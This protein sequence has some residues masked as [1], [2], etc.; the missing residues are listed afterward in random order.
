M[1]INNWPNLVSMFFDQVEANALKPMLHAKKD[2][3]WVS[4]SWQEVAKQVA[5]LAQALKQMGIEKGDRVVLVSENRPEWAIADLAIM[6]AGAI[7]VPTYTTYTPRDYLHILENSGAKAAIVSTKALSMT[8]LKAAHESEDLMHTICMEDPDLS[9]QLDV[10]VYDWTQQLAAQDGNVAMVKAWS[11][12]VKRDDIACLIYTSGT[13]GAPKGVMI[14]HGAILHNCEG[15]AE[16]IKELGL[17]NN[18]FLSFLP[19]S[20]AYEHSAGMYL[21]LSI[22]ADIWYAESLDKL[23]ANMEEASPTIMVVVPRLFEMLRLRLMRQM[24]KK[25]GLSSKLFDR[26]VALGMKKSIGE[27]SLSFF[28]KLQDSLLDIL[29]RK[30]VQKKFGGRIKALVSGGAPLSPDVGFFF[31]GLGLPLLQG[32]GQTESGPVVSVNPPSDPRMSTVGKIM[33]NTEVKIAADGEILIRGELVMKGYW[34]NDL[35][36][37]EALKEGWLHTGDIGILDNEGFLSITDRK[38]DILINDKGDNISPQRIEG[39]IALE[40]EIAQAM[41]YGDRKP[42]LVGLVVPDQE[43]LVEWAKANKKE[44]RK[45]ADLMDDPD[46]KKALDAAVRRVNGRLSNLEKIRK[47]IIAKEAFSIDNEQMTPTL[48]IRRHVICDA[49]QERLESLYGKK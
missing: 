28:E 4:L 32:Y 42:H 24:Q 13:G 44:S 21:P 8:F 35:A 5:Q 23:A 11:D 33:K 22:G 41:V 49:Y 40:N 6:A 9:Q 25:G 36:T 27:E 15:A 16:V 19:L 45:L 47:I 12:P 31:A 38:K 14:H 2:G 37:K 20:H 30:K 3:A 43:W 39:L 26:T 1:P 29:V 48:K 7:S 10:T 18:S 46:L 34:G 17:K